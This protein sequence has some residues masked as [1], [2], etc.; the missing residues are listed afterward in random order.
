MLNSLNIIDSY[1]RQEAIEDGVLINVSEPASRA[2]I[3]YPV[4]ITNELWHRFIKGEIKEYTDGRLW[5]V[6]WMF[7]LKAKT[8]THDEFLFNV[9]FV[10]GGQEKLVTIKAICAPGDD[11]SPCITLMLPC[12]D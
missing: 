4:A 9:S 5:D 1:S 12:E 11:I 3:K 8:I 2:G 6:L 10:V 7:R